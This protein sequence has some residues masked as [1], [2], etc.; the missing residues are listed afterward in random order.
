MMHILIILT[1]LFSLSQEKV[2]LYIFY[3]V[4]ESENHYLLLQNNDDELTGHY[5]GCEYSGGHGIFFYSCEVKDLTID[6][7]GN[8]EFTIGE[9]QLFEKSQFVIR[10]SSQKREDSIGV[11]RYELKYVGKMAG[12]S[13]ELTCI[14]PDS[15]CWDEKMLFVKSDS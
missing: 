14:S 10:K 15:E 11:S 7:K 4:N 13:I 9:R 3:S 1:S 6:K 2:D 8:I 5:F 12:S